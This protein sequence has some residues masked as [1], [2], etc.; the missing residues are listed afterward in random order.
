MIYVKDKNICFLEKPKCGSTSLKKT[1]ISGC[2]KKNL[3]IT[4]K[5][6]VAVSYEYKNPDYR[7]CGLDSARQRLR[8]LGF[9]NE[10]TEFVAI[11]RNP[12]DIIN[13][14]Y[15]YDLNNRFG[16]R[17]FRYSSLNEMIRTAHYRNF[18]DISYFGEDISNLKIFKLEE[19]DILSDFLKSRLNISGDFNYVNKNNKNKKDLV[20]EESIM[21]IIK[22]D[23]YPYFK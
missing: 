18:T 14:M 3:Y 1:I 4:K 22:K 19:L 2:D 6:L 13:S 10:K 11:I 17:M 9:L 15:Y 23:F 20:I 16:N 5:N 8:H 12:I 7:H 21:S